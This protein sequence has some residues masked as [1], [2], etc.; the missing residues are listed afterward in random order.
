M[1]ATKNSSNKSVAKAPTA[2]PATKGY[3]KRPMWQWVALYIIV[4]GLA[5]YLIYIVFFRGQGLGY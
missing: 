2:K 4:G 5:Y 3:G 1:A